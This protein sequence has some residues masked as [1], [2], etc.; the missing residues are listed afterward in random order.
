MSPRG[1]GSRITYPNAVKPTPRKQAVPK[2]VPFNARPGARQFQAL[3][4][5]KEEMKSEG[6]TAT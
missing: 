1:R 6:K 2:C 3:G 4:E 5:R